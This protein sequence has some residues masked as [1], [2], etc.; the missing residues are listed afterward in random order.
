LTPQSLLNTTT[1]SAIGQSNTGISMTTMVMIYT[2]LLVTI[3]S[4]T[5]ILLKIV[6]QYTVPPLF[7]LRRSP[8]L[9]VGSQP[10]LPHKGAPHGCLSSLISI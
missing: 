10:M 5:L 3:F 1:T 8:T 7:F 9:R 6:H 2:L 4:T